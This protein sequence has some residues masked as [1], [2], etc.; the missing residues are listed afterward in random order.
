[1]ATVLAVTQEA[2]F[3]QYTAAQAAI[4]AL[5][6][7]GSYPPQ[8]YQ[9]IFAS[10]PPLSTSETSILVDVG[11]GT[12]KVT[13]DLARAFTRSIGADPSTGMIGEAENAGGKT[14]DGSDIEYLVCPAEEIGELLN[15][16]LSG[17]VDLIVAG[18]AAHWFDMDKFW[19]GAAKLLKP[20]G[21][22]A[23]W[24]CASMYCHRAFVFFKL[25]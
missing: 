21:A 9:H 15:G 13:Q 5:G 2:T 3:T 18:M 4:Y 8:L 17:R 19:T 10:I 6:R 22:V 1:M 16:E 11:C 23:L 25:R 7:A 24:T 20:G 14:L 12:G